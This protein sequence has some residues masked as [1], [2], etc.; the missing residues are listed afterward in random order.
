MAL[1]SEGDFE[2]IKDTSRAV[3]L[4]T[5]NKDYSKI[6]LLKRNIQKRKF[7]GVSWGN[8]GGKIE[9]GEC[10]KDAILRES[11][12]EVGVKF[13]EDDLELLHIKEIPNVREDHHPIHFFYGIS[14][15][16]DEEINIDK[17]SEGY[18]WFNLNEL[19][20]DM[21]DSKE[22]ILF[23]KSKFLKNNSI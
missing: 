15:K 23:L 21:F 18:S 13:N 12:E 2:K 3:F 19:P 17:E 1:N 11:F 8:I 9:P 4:I 14:I 7:W 20:D 16:E 22:F 10:S 6:L 5:F